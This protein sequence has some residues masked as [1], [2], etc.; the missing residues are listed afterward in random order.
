MTTPAAE[1]QD[2]DFL[3]GPRNKKPRKKNYRPLKFF[4]HRSKLQAG[5]NASPTHDRMFRSIGG[6]TK[7]GA[8][9]GEGG[10]AHRSLSG[11][12]RRKCQPV[13]WNVGKRISM[14]D[15]FFRG[16]LLRGPIR[17]SGSWRSA[18][19]VVKYFLACYP[20]HELSLRRAPQQSP[21]PLSAW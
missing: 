4:F 16:F 9:A 13:F 18:A 17:K 21:P 2:P 19:G 7:G 8:E 20:E 6:A 1:R 12:Y 11:D 5:D 15:I 14:R 3:I 10:V